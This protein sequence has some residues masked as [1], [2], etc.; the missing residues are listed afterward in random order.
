MAASIRQDIRIGTRV[1]IREK[2]ASLI[3]I[4]VLAIG[5]CAV[6]TQ[7]SVVQAV[8]LRGFSFPNADRMVSVQFIDPTAT[9][10]FGVSSQEFSLDYEEM[11]EQQTS[12]EHTVAYIN[13][14]T[15]N[16]T[17]DG[18][19]RRF[20]GAYV[21][22]EFLSLL[23]IEPV[24]GRDF[25]PADNEPGSPKVTILSH[26]LWQ[27]EFGGDLNVLGKAVRLNGKPATVVG[28][29]EKGFAFPINEELWIPLFNEYPPH[30]RNLLDPVTNTVAIMALTRKGVSLS[31]ANADLSVI[32]SRLAATYPDTNKAYSAALV[33][34]LIR[35][36]TPLQLR[37]VLLTM[38]AFCVG[39]LVL[40]CANVMNLQFARAS[41]RAPELAI[42]SS[43]GATRLRLVRQMLT[44]S[45]LLAVLGAVVGVAGAFYATRLLMDVTHN[46]ANPIPSYI[47]IH[48]DGGVLAFIAGATILSALISGLIPAYTA[49]RSNPSAVLKE[50][51]R[52]HSSRTLA[53]L[54]RG[55]VVF[56]IVITSILLVGSYLQLQSIRKQQ[57]IDHHYDTDGVLSAR[58]GLMEGDYPEI[59]SRSVFHD[60]A[61]RELRS[62]S[63]YAGVA[64][65]TRFQMIFS[66]F[67]PIEIEGVAY[68]DPKDR[69]NANFESVS[70]G[71]FSTL[72]MQLLEGRDLSA[73]DSDQKLPV[74]V[75]N[76]S[77]ARNHFGTE[78][79]LGRRFRSSDAQ[80]QVF[81]PWR[82]IVGV[83]SDVRMR[84]PFN[85]PA[86]DDAGFYVP[87]AASVLGP[88]APEP[89]PP[90]FVTLVVRPRGGG[91]AK[92]LTTQLAA[93]VAKLDPN[94][95]LYFVA[96]PADNLDAILGQNRIVATMF[97]IFGLVAVLLSA[98]GLY[99]VMSFT[100]NQRRHEVGT[101]MV[102]GADSRQIMGMVVKQGMRQLALGLAVGLGLAFAIARLGGDG[103]QQ[104]LF[105]VNPSDP[106]A[107]VS[108]S[109]LIAAVAFAATIIP[110]RR[111]SRVDPVR[112]MRSE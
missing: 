13:G 24:L 21:T 91:S 5:I 72:E 40:A 43:L 63:S 97:S 52:G 59:A 60:R 80:G 86:V 98:A 10:P 11:R 108:V 56:Q 27:R 82:T 67:G 48:I 110:A 20:T 38:L 22:D 68:A 2:T 109:L 50:S 58:L 106:L 14:A 99:G 1:L 112:A 25:E 89:T 44:E 26:Q 30:E 36:F 74:A 94:L 34:P 37:G 31:E 111:A 65:T 92:A 62:R 75:V 42:R 81:G 84:A 104:V 53:F 19:A 77:F 18:V 83:V 76:A 49:S 41:L 8:F 35:R 28:V 23:G 100:V 57:H 85:T 12:F 46:Q 17:I 55:L 66:G 96:T 69:P 64:F 7:F 47:D 29:M 33:E 95:P 16:M 103:L 70:D 93:D 51:G 102:L 101:R 87:L 71:F 61:L 3:S 90:Q 79:A 32:A 15:V 4:F 39:V 88:V 9:T 78:S 73:D 45:S 6:A 105:E 107:Y 54:N